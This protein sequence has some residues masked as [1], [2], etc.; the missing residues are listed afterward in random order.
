MLTRQTAFSSDMSRFRPVNIMEKKT[1][2]GIFRSDNLRQ[3]HWTVASI[4]PIPPAQ[5]CFAGSK[6]I[7]KESR[8]HCSNIE[9]G[10]AGE[11]FLLMVSRDFRPAPSCVFRTYTSK[12]TLE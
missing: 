3:K 9:L 10:E 12:P 8:H 7:Q 4:S 1:L 11:G 2:F 5:C 6:K